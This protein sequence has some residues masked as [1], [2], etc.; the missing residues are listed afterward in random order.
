MLLEAS[1]GVLRHCVG[2]WGP[3][4]RN[5]RVVSVLWPPLGPGLGSWGWA[6]M[7]P[8]GEVGLHSDSGYR[9]LNGGEDDEVKRYDIRGACL[10]LRGRTPNDAAVVHLIDGY[11]KSHR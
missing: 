10:L 11:C 7:T 2:A 4:A 1:W 9:R 8:T 3:S 6:L 5:V